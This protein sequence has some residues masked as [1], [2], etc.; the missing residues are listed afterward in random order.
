MKKKRRLPCP[1]ATPEIA[2]LS[3]PCV[4]SDVIVIGAGFAGLSAAMTLAESGRTPM[5]FE[6]ADTVGGM[7]GCFQVN[8]TRLEQCY[9]HLFAQDQ[10]ILDVLADLGLSERIR[11]KST[12]MGFYTD[13]ALH[14]FT[15]PMDLLT[16]RPVTLVDRLRFAALPFC[17]AVSAR[18]LDDVGAAE[19]LKRILGARA[20][21]RIM[22]PL[23]KAKFGLPGEEISAAFIRGRLAAR[24]RSRSPKGAREKLGYLEG[25]MQV[26]A[27]R[28]AKRIETAG[29]RILKKTPVVGIDTAENHRFAVITEVGRFE[30]DHVVFTPPAH[31]LKRLW[32]REDDLV[33]RLSDFKYRPVV[34]VT[35]GLDAPLGRHYWIN[36]TDPD[37]PF[38]VVVEHTQLMG[39]DYYGGDHIVYLA[40][41]TDDAS[42]IFQ[43]DD[44]ALMETF[45]A[46]LS[47]VF[48]AFGPDR[49]RWHN[50]YREASATPVFQKGYAAKIDALAKALPNG[51]HLAGNILTY[52][53]SRN[54]S[55]V[56]R[57]GISAASKIVYES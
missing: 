31:V 9:H 49:I 50:I 48:P 44:D 7:A 40:A 32:L 25:G 37:I 42:N 1:D 54:V 39:A 15:S 57:L 20:F 16:F 21:D 51:L 14:N 34:C 27:N 13:G 30:T 24:V 12:P 36:V 8:D 19:W 45:T 28:M 5:V 38:G 47:R 53:G 23:I 11:W 29:G 2:V 10:Q 33:D 52:P 55:N 35:L 22:A 3:N 26:A 43:A 6:S 4:T 41:Y 46:G 18:A 17:A 56:I